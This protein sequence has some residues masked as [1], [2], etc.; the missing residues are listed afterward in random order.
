M[1][2]LAA[3]CLAILAAA[4]ASGAAEVESAGATTVVRVVASREMAVFVGDLAGTAYAHRLEP[5]DS[6]GTS[7][8]ALAR[9]AGCPAP[10]GATLLYEMTFVQRPLAFGITD[11]GDRAWTT[12]LE[13]SSCR[14]VAQ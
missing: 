1:R 7:F 13:I 14:A 6:R 8:I 4:C 5:R 10:G 9:T 2:A 3:T 11:E 12:N